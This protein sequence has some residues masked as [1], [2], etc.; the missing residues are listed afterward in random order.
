MF[1]NGDI[2]LPLF[3][4]PSCQ[5][6]PDFLEVEIFIM[7][8]FKNAHQHKISLCLL[9]HLHFAVCPN[10]IKL[11]FSIHHCKSVI[12]SFELYIHYCILLHDG[13]FYISCK[14]KMTVV[15]KI[16]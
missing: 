16:K 7:I 14:K 1:W 6:I 12:Y 11:D 9:K 4:M 8:V 3:M 5:S 2:Y 13:Y 15:C 10:E